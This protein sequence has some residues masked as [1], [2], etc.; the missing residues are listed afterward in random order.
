MHQPVKTGDLKPVESRTGNSKSEIGVSH[1]NISIEPVGQ[2]ISEKYQ[3]SLL[4]L[5]YTNKNS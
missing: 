4:R 1:Y 2:H 3:E 5:K